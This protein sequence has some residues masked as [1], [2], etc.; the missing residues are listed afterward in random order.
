MAL[1][2]IFMGTSDFAVPILNSIYKS[3]H[4]I[5]TV[6]T[7]PPKKSNRGQK[8]SLSP[9][10]NFFKKNNLNVI[11]PYE[12]NE[13]ENKRIANL[14]PDVVVVVAYGK[15]IPSQI[16]DN[17]KIMFLNVHASFYQGGG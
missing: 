17:N 10:H 3:D 9:V 7:Q 13:N 8:I 14:S 1:N 11:H 2:L 4:K 5:L 16:L 12:L 6:Y 15:I